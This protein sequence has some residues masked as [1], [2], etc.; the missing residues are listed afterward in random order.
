MLR[1]F[2]HSI[3]PLPILAA[4]LLTY[5]SE[6]VATFSPDQIVSWNDLAAANEAVAASTIPAASEAVD[7]ASN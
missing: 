2:L 6:P 1:L 3:M 4:T 7:F 5:S